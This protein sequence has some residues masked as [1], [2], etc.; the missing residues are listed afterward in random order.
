MAEYLSGNMIFLILAVVVI[1]VYIIN[2]MRGNKMHK[3]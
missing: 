3:K 2:R 1:I